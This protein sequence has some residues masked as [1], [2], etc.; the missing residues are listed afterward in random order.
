MISILGIP[1]DASSSFMRGPAKAPACIREALQSASSNLSIENGTTFD[2]PISIED[3]GDLD[4][5]DFESAQSMRDGITQAI[6][7]IVKKGHQTLVLGGDHSISF[8]V[9]RAHAQAY[10]DLH[11]VQFDAHPDLYDHLDGDRYSHACPFARLLEAYPHVGLTQ[12]GIRTMNAHCQLQADRFGVRV[13]EMKDLPAPSALDIQGPVYLSIDLDVL[14]PAFAP[15]VSHYEPGGL[16]VRELLTFVHSIRNRIVGADVVE[17]NPTR[18][19]DSQTAMVAAKLVKEL[20][21]QM[22]ANPF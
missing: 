20:A 3:L 4:L 18:D 15:G 7:A 8:P 17:L 19:R 12:I 14:D 6:A 2:D 9:I 11:I 5:L 22:I 1:Y 16:S 10:P 21:G 13:F